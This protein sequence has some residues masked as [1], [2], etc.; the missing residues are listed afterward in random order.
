[1]PL[2]EKT[3]GGHLQNCLCV[4]TYDLVDSRDS[5][6]LSQALKR[7]QIQIIVSCESMIFS[8]GDILCA[9]VQASW[10]QPIASPKGWSLYCIFAR[11]VTECSG[12]CPLILL[13][14]HIP[15]AR[16]KNLALRV[17]TSKYFWCKNLTC[18][19]SSLKAR[20]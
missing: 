12:V 17:C 11:A 18:G 19:R 20:I 5:W 1:M 10:S 3:Q 8:V 16:R 7:T 6:L 9:T 4:L 2:G 15:V 14:K 13:I